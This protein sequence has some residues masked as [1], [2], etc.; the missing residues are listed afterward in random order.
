MFLISYVFLPHL[1]KGHV[2]FCHY[3]APIVRHELFKYKSTPLKPLIRIESNL[4]GSIFIRSFKNVAVFVLIWQQTWTPWTILISDQ[5]KQKQKS[6]P[7][8]DCPNGIKLYRHQLKA[9]FKACLFCPNRTKNMAANIVSDRLK[10]K[11]K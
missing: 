11:K 1:A 6:F 9:L 10:N 2:G 4:T 8:T 5:L 7:E 3:L